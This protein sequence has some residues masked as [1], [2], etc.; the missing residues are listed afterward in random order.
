MRW[1]LIFALFTIGLGI[2]LHEGG[3]IPWPYMT[4]VGR[5]PGDLII[6]KNG[7]DIYL[8]MASCLIASFALSLITSLFR[9]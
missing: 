7:V 5:L 4:W 3:E 8:P 6:T 2:Y 9:K 1:I